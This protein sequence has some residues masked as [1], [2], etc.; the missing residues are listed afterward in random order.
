MKTEN[1]SVDPAIIRRIPSV[2]EGYVP[3]TFAQLEAGLLRNVIRSL[4]PGT[5][6]AFVR[7]IGRI[8][9]ALDDPRSRKARIDALI[10]ALSLEQELAERDEVPAGLRRVLADHETALTDA[11]GE[12]GEPDADA[13]AENEMRRR[14]AKRDAAAKSRMAEEDA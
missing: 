1:I 5:D 3:K 11:I 12:C 6:L 4:R 14:T 10:D 8:A 7:R 2:A 13:I 9:D